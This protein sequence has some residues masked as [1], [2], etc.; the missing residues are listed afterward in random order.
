MKTFEIT[1]TV[2][3][4]VTRRPALSR[5]FEAEGIDYCCGGKKSL[6]QV[7]RETGRNPASLL[8]RLEASASEPAEGPDV[9]A[10]SMSLSELAGHIE[11]TH[12]AYLKRELPR[13]DALTER[14]AT[15]H[16]D[17]DERLPDVRRVFLVFANELATHMMKEEQILFPMIRRLEESASAPA[18]HCGSI[19]NPI[20]QMEHEHD[21][22]GSALEQMRLLT[23]G[24]TPPNWACNTYR[25]ML[26]GL[27]HLERDM[28]R[29]V[30][31]ENNVLFPRALDREARLAGTGG[32]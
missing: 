14:V 22:A 24:Y 15:V 27:A 30:H 31:K 11:Q 26:D 16:G 17:R 21:G 13:L 7:C 3:E 9:D 19:A 1:D 8:A 18:F 5:V 25:A 20:R 29:H 4:I 2:A 23:D 32:K 10:A 28:H 6:D 12:H